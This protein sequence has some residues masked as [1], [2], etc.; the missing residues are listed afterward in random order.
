M[1]DL[2]PRNTRQRRQNVVS[3]KDYI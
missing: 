3:R 2:L 1:S